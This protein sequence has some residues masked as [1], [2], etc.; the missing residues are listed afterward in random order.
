MKEFKDKAHNLYAIQRKEEAIQ[1]SVSKV[2]PILLDERSRLFTAAIN[3]YIPEICKFM[4]VSNK[5]VNDLMQIDP[6]NRNTILHRICTK[7]RS[8]AFSFLQSTLS[9]EELIEYLFQ[10]NS[11]DQRPYEYACRYGSISIAKKIFDIKEMKDKISNDYDNLYRIL[12]HLLVYNQ[13]KYLINYI[14]SVLNITKEKMSVIFKHKCQ[15]PPDGKFISRVQYDKFTIVGG[16]SYYGTVNIMTHLS[17]ILSVDAL[18]EHVFAKD[19]W[20]D[21]AL[22]GAIE[23][24]KLKMVKC[25]VSIKPVKEKLLTDDEKLGAAL[26][27]LNGNFEESVAKYLVNELELTE[28][29]LYELNEI[30][31]LNVHQIL[32]V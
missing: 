8:K 25:I 2:L 22:Q 9:D 26:K 15:T 29:K 28:T 3:G 21:N 16:V 23:R 12:F 11:S 6:S 24:K 31:D 32:S 1:N 14:I 19:G 5:S 17:T 4:V 13:N 7:N 18:C 27:T 10:S 30:Y 20:G